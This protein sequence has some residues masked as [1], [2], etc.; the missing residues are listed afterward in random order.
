MNSEL[1]SC[2]EKQNYNCFCFKDFEQRQICD[3]LTL[4]LAS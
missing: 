2:A 1:K 3:G 4:N